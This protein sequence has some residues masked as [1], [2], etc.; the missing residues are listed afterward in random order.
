MTV[1]EMQVLTVIRT[2]L[3]Q[4]A[5]ELMRIADALEDANSLKRFELTRKDG[6]NLDEVDME[7]KQ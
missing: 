2:A 7:D 1:I 3:P 6:L 5:K 4:I